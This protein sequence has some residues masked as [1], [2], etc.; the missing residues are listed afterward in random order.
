M[1]TILQWGGVALHQFRKLGFDQ[2]LPR[3]DRFAAR[4][5]L[6]P[7]NHLLTDAQAGRV[8]GAVREFFV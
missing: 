5:M 2:R 1:G 4:A 3:A 8:I 7:M 6:L